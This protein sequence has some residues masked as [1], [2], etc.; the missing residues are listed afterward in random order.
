MNSIRVLLGIHIIM[1]N[2]QQ[3]IKYR[4]NSSNVESFVSSFVL[5]R[6]QPWASNCDRKYCDD[7][8]ATERDVR[9]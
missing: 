9:P 7:A 4:N 8:T 5:S 6:F 2:N 1:M 3:I